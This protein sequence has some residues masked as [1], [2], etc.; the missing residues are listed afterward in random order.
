MTLNS[1]SRAETS[2]F[3]PIIRTGPERLL[4]GNFPIDRLR[5]ISTI[6]LPPIAGFALMTDR[7]NQDRI[8]LFLKAIE[9]NVTGTS[10]RYR[11]FSQGA[12]NRATD[13]WVTSQQLDRFLD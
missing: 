12:L 10:A 13:Q 5:P 9:C 8:L 6:V 11:Q 1:Y 4:R 3:L 2:R 7:K